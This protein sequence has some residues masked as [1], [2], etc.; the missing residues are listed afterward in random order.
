M[1]EQNMEQI[2]TMITLY[3]LHIAKAL[4]IFMVGRWIAKVAADLI[5]RALNRHSIEPT[6]VLFTKNILYFMFLVCVLIASL[7]EIGFQT[8]SLLAILG[9]AGLAVGLALQG[10]LSN[11]AAG[12][13]II[14]LKP[15]RLGDFI[16]GAGVSGVVEAIDILTTQLRTGDNKTIFIPNSK[17]TGDNIINFSLKPNRRVDVTVGVSYSSDL[18]K[19]RDVLTQTIEAESRILKEPAPQIFCTAL[20]DSSVNFTIR[21]WVNTSDY[22]P[23][24]FALNEAVKRNFDKASIE[25]PFPQ[26]DLHI[27][28]KN[29]KESLA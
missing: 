12:F 27:H 8:A 29:S 13:L 1:L 6:V 17:L 16:E 5:S 18:D 11:L 26:R 25:I 22:W 28:Y 23:T 7:H 19:V 4:L 20:A 14:I 21:V 2:K 24:T 10:S 9:S 15:F 3:G